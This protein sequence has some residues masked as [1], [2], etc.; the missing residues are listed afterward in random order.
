MKSL[1]PVQENHKK[2]LM[3]AIGKH[4]AA[5]DASATGTGKT[6]VAADIAA[7]ITDPCFVVC[8]K[9]LVPM[10]K[11]EMADRSVEP[12]GVINYEKLRRG[13]EFGGWRGPQWVW[14]IP[15]GT[16]VIWDEVQ[17]CKSP[18]SLNSKLLL[19]SKEHFNL[20]L[21]ATAAES[22][23]EMRALGYILGLHKL[24]NWWPWAVERGCRVDHW[25]H[26]AFDND[27]AILQELHKEIFPE[28]GH[29]LKV[30]D[31]AD[32][33]TETQ[34][35]LTP[36]D[37][38]NEVK[39]LYAEMEKELADL[40]ETMKNDSK[41]PG[42]QKLIITLRARQS[43]E[44]CKVP[45]MLEMIEDLRAEGQS[46]VVFVN[47]DDTLEALHGR[48]KE[49][50]AIIR[51]G[52]SEAYRRLQMEHFQENLVGVLLCNIQAGGVGLSLHDLK[53]GHPRTAI[54]SP[55]W[56]A[57]DVLQALGRIH[58][59]EGKT[60]TQQHVLFAAGTIEEQVHR[61]VQDKIVNIGILND[62]K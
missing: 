25:G 32:H 39:K 60:P 22:P 16:F 28:R 20:M 56:S 31:L 59:A 21:S 35:I 10:W 40:A 50:A 12:I 14:K 62:G 30:S 37:F 9:A 23:A 34:I 24:G 7:S 1:Y 51:G 8:P 42:A 27:P 4:G 33:F 54:I 11:A 49:P 53:G 47:F 58:R 13:C 48:M 41:S 29:R 43:V 57:F 5:L 38:G 15:T 52:Q 45:L 55:S 36:L 6:V 18:N 3:D 2:I 44:L 46:V 19:A 17:K 61:V 26:L